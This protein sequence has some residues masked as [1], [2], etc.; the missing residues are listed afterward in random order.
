[1]SEAREPRVMGGVIIPGRTITARV[2]FGLVVITL[3]LLFT[4]DNL[5]L[6][7]SG[8]VLQWWPA[9]LVAYGVARLTG[10]GGPANLSA[11][12]LFTL[13]GGWMLLHNLGLISVG[14]G[15]LWPL[16]LVLVGVTMVMGGMRRARSSSQN[17]ESGASLSAFAFWSSSVRK[18]V[19][20]N[21]RGGDVTAVMGGHDIDLRSAGTQDGPAIIDLLVWMGG[22][23][24]FVPDNWRVTNEAVVVMGAIT[25]ETRPLVGEPKGHVILRGLVL[26]GGVELKN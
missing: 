11:G 1:M 8:D 5:G 14:I 22:V 17:V 15:Q 4:L 24:L 6:V 20:P 10:L 25:D 13:V 9:V 18:I 7:D 3:G 12:A 23:E 21:F 19:S 2:I 16:V 26:M